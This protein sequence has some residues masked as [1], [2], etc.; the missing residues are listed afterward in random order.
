MTNYGY[1]DMRI[2]YTFSKENKVSLSLQEK[3]LTVFVANDKI[4]AFKQNLGSWEICI[5]YHEFD[6]FSILKHFSDE[7]ESDLNECD[8]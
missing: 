4:R 5:C 1:S 7:I 3:H 8:F 2:W 6:S